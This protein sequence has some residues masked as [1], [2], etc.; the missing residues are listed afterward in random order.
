MQID[1]FSDI[2]YDMD[3]QGIATLS[4]NTPHRKNA[5]SSLTAL[6][7]WWAI[8]HFEN[9]DKAH[10]LIVTGAANPD[11]SDPAKQA[12]SSGGYFSPDV[13][14][15]LPE[16]IMQ[17]ID[18]TDIALKKLTLKSFQCDKPIFAA[19]NGL[20]MGAGITFPLAAADQMY[21]SEYAWIEF[22]FAR[23]GLT[24]EMGSTYLLP[25]LLGPQKAK[26][27]LF[28][29]ERISAESALDLGLCSD[30]IPHEELMK[31]TREQALKLIPPNGA[32]QAVRA[33]KHAINEPRVAQLTTALDLENKALGEQFNSADFAE[34]ITAR[35]ERRAPVFSGS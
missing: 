2:T 14:E 11:N 33:M 20:A 24:A 15:G 5:I 17:Q 3:D 26:Q 34:S 22:P 23:L 12:F 29:P 31:Y 16:E 13:Y 6:E 7:T 18:F 35:M 21:L 28:Y 19:V 27:V 32:I 4:L 8:D 10:A 25:Q 30:I 9:N 1:Q